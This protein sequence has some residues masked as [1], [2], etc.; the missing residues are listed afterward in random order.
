MLQ[1]L[2][3]ASPAST[4]PMKVIS[5]PGTTWRCCGGGYSVVQ[6]VLADAAGEPFDQLMARQVLA[7]AGMASGSFTQPASKAIMAR[8]AWPHDSAGK[9]LAGPPSYPELA[10]AGLWSTPTDLAN[11][12]IALQRA[13]NGKP[14]ALLDRKNAATMLAPVSNAYALGVPDAAQLY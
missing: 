11:F 1:V 4:E 10:A 8:A 2:D 3:G 13:A 9:A 5:P 7:L 12:A 14:G 6:L